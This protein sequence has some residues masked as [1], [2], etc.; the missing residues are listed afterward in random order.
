MEKLAGKVK[1]FNKAKGYG[2]IVN[3]LGEDVFFHHDALE[4][5][6][7][8]KLVEGDNVEYYQVK[9]EKGLQATKVTRVE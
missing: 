9:Y 8:K 7:H 5:D 4:G 2:F 1:W 3:E 6:E